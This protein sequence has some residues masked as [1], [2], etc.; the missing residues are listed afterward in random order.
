MTP[1][2]VKQAH[3]LDTLCGSG[4]IAYRHLYRRQ[5]CPSLSHRHFCPGR[6]SAWASG[7]EHS[8]ARRSCFVAKGACIGCTLLSRWGSESGRNTFNLT[9]KSL[10]SILSGD[11]TYISRKCAIS[12]AGRFLIIDL[13]EKKI[14]SFEEAERK[15]RSQQEIQMV[16]GP[17]RGCSIKRSRYRKHGYREINV[18]LH[19]QTDT[20]KTKHNVDALR[21]AAMGL[22]FAEC[23]A[24]A[25]IKRN[26]PSTL[27]QSLSRAK[28]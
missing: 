26:C 27:L 25:T 16:S 23:S 19:M 6:Q 5:R 11:A 10:I 14:Y 1:L 13:E 20:R 17:T 2:G 18:K 4:G 28:K 21:R 15:H 3:F 7:R 9:M 24:S 12:A 8:A 22:G